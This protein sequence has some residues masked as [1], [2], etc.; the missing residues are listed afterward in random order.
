MIRKQNKQTIEDENENEKEVTR[1][2]FA[3]NIINITRRF[4]K[5][6]FF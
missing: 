5:I 3:Y 2:K 6:K 4:K 1:S